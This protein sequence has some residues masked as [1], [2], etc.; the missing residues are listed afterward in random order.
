MS[1]FSII[2]MFYIVEVKHFQHTDIFIF[3]SINFRVTLYF[4]TK[5]T[6]I[7]SNDK[8]IFVAE[9]LKAFSS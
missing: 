3:T 2:T 9:L 5:I 4:V 1:F 8:F 6:A 7:Y